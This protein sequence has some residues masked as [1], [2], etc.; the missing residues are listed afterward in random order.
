L[1]AAAPVYHTIAVASGLRLA[2]ARAMTDVGERQAK[3]LEMIAREVAGLCESMEDLLGRLLGHR[4]L[5]CSNLLV[6]GER[7]FCTLCEEK[8]AIAQAAGITPGA[9]HRNAVA[10]RREKLREHVRAGRF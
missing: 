4:C 6:T 2:Q 8:I 7:A 9:V 3:A 5:A 1:R 10:R